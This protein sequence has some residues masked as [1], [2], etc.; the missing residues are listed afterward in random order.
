MT[1][2]SVTTIGNS[3]LHYIGDEIITED[4]QSGIVTGHY[5]S[6]TVEAVIGKVE[7]AE[8]MQSWLHQ[9][10]SDYTGKDGRTGRVLKLKNATALS[11][12]Y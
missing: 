1:T 6:K 7:T 8:V 9:I 12:I 2:Q 4:G 3:N 10:G 11:V 5:D